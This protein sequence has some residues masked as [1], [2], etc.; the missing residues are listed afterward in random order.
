MKK[1]VFLFALVL[2]SIQMVSA[3]SMFSKEP[4]P[5]MTMDNSLGSILMD[6]TTG[7]KNNLLKGE[8]AKLDTSKKYYPN[9]L[10]G[11][12]QVFSRPSKTQFL[13]H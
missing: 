6:L 9:R 8:A 1:I 4:G 11:A 2:F 5:A 3:Q 7:N 12:D 13:I 10:F